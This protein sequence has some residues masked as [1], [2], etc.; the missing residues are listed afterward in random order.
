MLYSACMG[1]QDLVRNDVWQIGEQVTTRRD[2]WLHKLKD[3]VPPAN[4]DQLRFSPLNGPALF[5]EKCLESAITA[6]SVQKHDKVQDDLLSK[7]SNMSRSGNEKQSAPKGRFPKQ[8][9]QDFHGKGDG[10]GSS[11]SSKDKSQDQGFA[12]KQF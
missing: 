7:V 8:S 12:N 3:K 6:A 10:A 1:V 9:F 4:I 11:S 5:D 2:A